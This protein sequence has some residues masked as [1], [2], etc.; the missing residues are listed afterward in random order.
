MKFMIAAVVAVV[1]VLALATL[2]QPDTTAQTSTAAVIPTAAP[3][4]D[5]TA[6]YPPGREPMALPPDYRDTFVNYAR[7]DRSDGI[8]RN[9][10]ISPDSMA[11]VAAG[12]PL[13]EGTTLIIEA[14]FSDGVGSDG[15]LS[16]DTLDPEIHMAEFRSTWRIEDLAASSHVGGW[17]FGA[18]DYDTGEVVAETPLNDCFSCHEGA[19]RTEFVFSDW[20]LDS[21]AA[22]GEVVYRY[23]PRPGRLPC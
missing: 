10:Y 8:S 2:T 18:F 5:A 14:Y 21:Y 23:C 20:V 17:N 11:A 13:P 22:S 16:Q 7:V 19:Q 6:T 9:L 4:A 12:Q 15:R 3:T 1:A